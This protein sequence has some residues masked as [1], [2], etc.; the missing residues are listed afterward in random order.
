MSTSNIYA[1]DEIRKK[2]C[3]RI[4]SDIEFDTDLSAISLIGEGLNRNNSVL[5]ET[6]DLLELKGIKICGIATTSFRISLLVPDDKIK[7]SVILCHEKW[8][9]K[10]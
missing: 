9:V 6:I 2:L 10:Q 7:E 8:I 3:E 1:W 5:I 4:K